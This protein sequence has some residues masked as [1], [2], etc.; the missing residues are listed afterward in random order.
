MTRQGS[1]LAARTVAIERRFDFG[2]LRRMCD[3]PPN[4]Y[5]ASRSQEN[6]TS[7]WGWKSKKELTNFSQVSTTIPNR[8]ST[9]F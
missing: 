5:K 6:Q 2:Q 4:I 8:G 1:T 9:R 7:P 3:I